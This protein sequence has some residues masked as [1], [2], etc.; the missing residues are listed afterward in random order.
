MLPFNES[1]F[2]VLHSIMVKKKSNPQISLYTAPFISF[3][4][5]CLLST[6]KQK[7]GDFKE[8]PTR[9]HQHQA[10]NPFEMLPKTSYFAIR[11]R[12]LGGEN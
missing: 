5:T 8:Q 2:R 1:C 4:T 11:R 9:R 3:C 12:C 6:G 7:E 10:M